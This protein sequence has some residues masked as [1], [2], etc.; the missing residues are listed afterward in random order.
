MIVM[1]TYRTNFP[2]TCGFLDAALGSL[3]T[4]RPL[5]WW[6]FLKHSKKGPVQAGAALTNAQKTPV[7]VFNNFSRGYAMYK[8]ET[9]NFIYVL[10][11]A[12]KEFERAPKDTNAQDFMLAK[13]LHETVHWAHEGREGP[14]DEFGAE[15]EKE[16]FHDIL[17]AFWHAGNW[18][19]IVSAHQNQE[20]PPDPVPN[21]QQ[22]HPAPSLRNSQ[23]VAFTNDDITPDLP[24]G[25]RNNNPGNIKKGQAW[26]GLA[27]LRHMRYFQRRE[28]V[29]EVFAEPEWGLR[30][31]FRTL[32]TY[33]DKH[34][35]DTVQKITH[36]WAP[37]H[38]NNNPLD[39]ARFVAG[40]MGIGIS[41]PVDT[42]NFKH[43]EPIAKAIVKMEN[44][45]QPYSDAQFDDA[46]QRSES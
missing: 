4:E 45:S 1:S 13:V 6:A 5:V 25:I 34:N 42:H 46:F 14:R 9:P 44:S 36:R 10:D 28:E 23:G 27:D 37:A 15:F 7:L 22:P 21:P 24:R 40:S 26:Q 3:R 8:K 41:D 17:P 12:A 11:T 39:Y 16:A 38:D 32:K 29:F 31:I 30:A 2:R 18:E 33:R 43:A 20:T 19:A 35:L